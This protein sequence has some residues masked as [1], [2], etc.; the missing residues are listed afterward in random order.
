MSGKKKIFTES[1][2]QELI[3]LVASL[4][5]DDSLDMDDVIMYG[6]D[7]ISNWLDSDLYEFASEY[8]YYWCSD[9]PD[10]EELRKNDKE[11]EVYRLVEGEYGIYKLLT[12]KKKKAK[13]VA[14]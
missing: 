7:G 5:G 13:K 11:F 14:S 3:Q 9:E 8:G 10:I 2:R 12:A 1:T 6:F 4:Y